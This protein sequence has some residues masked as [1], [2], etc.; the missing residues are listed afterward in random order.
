MHY[1]YLDGSAGLSGDMILGAL[2]DLGVSPAA[3]KKDMARLRLPVEIRARR[4]RRG[5][6]GALKVDV[7]VR[8]KGSPARRFEDISAL[9][10]KSGFPAPIRERALAV[11]NALFKAEAKV[12]GHT[13]KNTHL[14]EAGADDAL[15]DIVGACHLLDVLNIRKVYISPLNVG[16]GWVKAAHGVLPVP[17]PAVAE[18]LKGAPVYAAWAETELVTPTGAALASVLAESFTALPELCYDRIGYGAGS[19]DI[20][21]FSN[22]LRAFY[23]RE[24]VFRPEKRLFVVEAHIDD[25]TPQVLAAFLDTA[26]EQ[27]ALDAALTPIVMKKGRLATKLTLLAEADRIDDLVAGVFRET[28]SIG[29]RYYPVERRVLDRASSGVH[30]AGERIGIKVSRFRE[31]PVNAQPEFSDCLRA[32]RKSGRPL[33]EIQRL[34]AERYWKG[35]PSRP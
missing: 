8:D 33:K 32:A 20:P 16:S 13:F 7:H 22:V 29:V 11:F 21:G 24:D 26:L 4:V 23:G 1:L 35:K 9:I 3:F 18:L 5:A 6:L 14:H 15:V 31:T 34:A 12:H 10:K 19:R 25:S 2:L 27:G 17:P 28:T 30:V